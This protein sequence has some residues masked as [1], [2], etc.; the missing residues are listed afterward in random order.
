ME[1]VE[2]GED[3]VF[4]GEHRSLPHLFESRRAAFGFGRAT[5]HLWTY[6]WLLAP[7]DRIQNRFGLRA[8]EIFIWVFVDEDHR[9]VDAGA[10]AFHFDPAEFAVGGNRPLDR[11]DV[12]LARRDH[13][14]GTAH[15]AWR[16][17]ADLHG[18]FPHRGRIEHRV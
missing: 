8:V 10:Q 2:I 6:L 18:M 15:P 5:P 16:G 14:V 1:P 9:R 17:G 4:I 7:A 11:M 13:L 12:F 3:A